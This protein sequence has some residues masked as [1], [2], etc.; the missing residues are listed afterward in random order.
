MA[1]FTVPD[2]LRDP[3]FRKLPRDQQLLGLR[4]VDAEFGGLPEEAQLAALDDPEFQPSSNLKHVEPPKSSVPGM[5]RLGDLPRAGA[6]PARPEYN[7]SGDKTDALTKAGLYVDETVGAVFRPLADMQA[8]VGAAMETKG[9]LP[10]VGKA[11]RE[12]GEER[13][14]YW[15]PRSEDALKALADNP[16]VLGNVDWWLNRGV[17]TA[18]QMVAF[19]AAGEAV[20]P[21]AGAV[22]GAAGTSAKVGA[23]AELGAGLLAMSGLEVLV[24][25]GGAAKQVYE[26]TGNRELA[27]KVFDRTA[28]YEAVPTV[29]GNL[30]GLKNP[31][32]KSALSKV[33]LSMLSEGA[34]EGAQGVSQRYAYNVTMEEAGRPER[35]SLWRNVPEEALVGGL[36]GGGIG[37]VMEAAGDRAAARPQATEVQ[38]GAAPALPEPTVERAPFQPS[39]EQAQELANYVATTETGYVSVLKT[40]KL[41]GSSLDDARGA[42]D[43]MVDLG[44]LKRTG[45]GQYKVAAQP[46]AA[47]AVPASPEVS[48][49]PAPV[50]NEKEEV[51]LAET[52][53]EEIPAETVET[54][55]PMDE[56]AQ[57]SAE[58]V[59]PEAQ[60]K[61]PADETAKTVADTVQREAETVDP[62]PETVPLVDKTKTRSTIKA[63]LQTIRDRRKN[64]LARKVEPTTPTT[65]VFPSP[66]STQRESGELAAPLYSKGTLEQRGKAQRLQGLL[67]E[68][69]EFRKRT[70]SAEAENDFDK[71][72]NLTAKRLTPDFSSGIRRLT[73]NRLTLEAHK[74][75]HRADWDS[76][77]LQEDL[78]DHR[79]RIQGA[80]TETVLRELLNLPVGPAVL[81]E[82]IRGRRDDATMEL[83]RSET[84]E[85]GSLLLPS[86]GKTLKD[87][88]VA[89]RE[90]R[91]A[92][93]A[94]PV[95]PAAAQ[96]EQPKPQSEEPVES[97]IESFATKHYVIGKNEAIVTKRGDG[98]H[99]AVVSASKTWGGTIGVPGLSSGPFQSAK[100]AQ[101]ASLS[102]LL[103]RHIIETFGR[104]DRGDS[105]KASVAIASQVLKRQ[106]ELLGDKAAPDVM[107]QYR[108]LLAFARDIGG[109]S[110]WR[111][112]SDAKLDAVVDQ[113][114]ADII[115]GNAADLF[116]R[117]P[118]LQVAAEAFG[119]TTPAK[120]TKLLIS[121]P[122]KADKTKVKAGGKSGAQKPTGTSELAAT[123]AAGNKDPEA[124]EGAPAGDVPAVGEP[125]SATQDGSAGSRPVRGTDDRSLPQ[126]DGLQQ[127]EGD[128]PDGAGLAPG[129]DGSTDVDAKP[130]P[131]TTPVDLSKDYR[132]TPEDRLGQGGE[133]TKADDNIAALE[134][135]KTLREEGREATAE[136]KRKLVRYVG[137]GGLAQ[138]IFGYDYRASYDERT[139]WAERR[140]KVADLLSP[141]EYQA[142]QRSTLNAHYTSETVVSAMWRAV[143]RLGLKDGLRVLEP[144]SGTGN[145]FGLMPESML[146]GSRRMA[147]EIDP[148]TAE[149]FKHLYPGSPI[150]N[151]PY[152][153]AVIPSSYFDL[154]I[155][156]VPFADVRVV[157]PAFRRNRVVTQSV[158]DYFFA[159]AMEHVRPGGLVAFIT[160]R[161]TMDKQD[162]RVREYLADR[163]D[164]IGAWRLPNTAFRENARTEVDTDVLFLRKRAEGE[165]R[166]GADWLQLA[167]LKGLE[168]PTWVNEYFVAHP[169]MVL[170]TMELTR[171][172][173][174]ANE[175]TV[176]G[177]L[178]PELLEKAINALPENIIQPPKNPA[179]APTNQFIPAAEFGDA[180]D[181][182]IG[183]I[184]EKDGKFF[185]KEKTGFAELKI[186]KTQENRMRG[187]LAVRTAVREV[188]REQLAS[189]DDVALQ[190]AQRAL[191]KTYDEFVAKFGPISS[192][193]N[194]KWI[195]ED[196]DN[197][198]LL[199][200]ESKYDRKAGTV[201]KTAIFTKRTIAR[202]RAAESAATAKEGM[203]ITLAER[204]RLDIG[205]IAELVGRTQ[206]QVIDD[207]VA[208]DLIFNN[209]D[210]GS[211]QVAEEYLSGDVRGKLRL[212]ER[213]AKVD[214]KFERNVVALRAVQPVDLEPKDISAR[215]GA[216]WIPAEVYAEFLETVLD[217]PSGLVKIT[218]IATLGEWSVDAG[219]F[220]KTVLATKK[221]GTSR[222]AADELMERLLNAKPII[223]IDRDPDGRSWKN[224]SE[225]VLAQERADALNAEFERWLW[226]S[227]HA[228][229]LAKLYN[230]KFNNW[231]LRKYNG[232]HLTFPGMAKGFLRANDLDPHQE[233]R[234][235]RAELGQYPTGARGGR[236]QNLRDDR[237]RRGAEAH[238]PRA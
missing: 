71:D 86:E 220:G 70:E 204:G 50:E 178:T 110:R 67:T 82:W 4:E 231:V 223:V 224:E 140:R 152:Q 144:A 191:G 91:R 169:E 199:A 41:L 83:Q 138:K 181:L 218:E 11:I 48:Q 151:L 198:L 77:I 156:N 66:D 145:F 113:A 148:V 15:A 74:R 146:D 161:Y 214:S 166:A 188:F 195:S 158:H 210:G 174:R 6:M 98:Y 197:P 175:L 45:N 163:A 124:L 24:D 192:K 32:V 13:A 114:K 31:A 141:E 129:G 207:L 43:A 103:G 10:G 128:R 102:H 119:A 26:Q 227:R 147:V 167:E 105:T 159:K 229:R 53:V 209:P 22:A 123:N 58:T 225:T 234:M 60:T 38:R 94:E 96:I 56:T 21:A 107:Q 95:K 90:R 139:A 62:E 137:W 25:A 165:E 155:S 87:R 150:Q 118:M 51:P 235:A 89:A 33:A 153:E 208:E 149:I 211:W 189:D 72:V 117:M 64:R 42:L 79:E 76:E 16:E 200:L 194:Q 157:D 49:E 61:A 44:I 136:E 237:R 221:W 217:L 115:N 75:Q 37:G 30:I 193:E 202:P 46:A 112:T 81:E 106:R 236:G 78:Q 219:N 125:G 121:E 59:E 226:S 23:A 34:Q 9:I 126:G 8:N 57:A 104:G 168:S 216:S 164:L 132:I 233:R 122:G 215:I 109:L 230:E 201:E 180:R 39:E 111:D 142:A 5:E 85:G 19:I 36:F 120:L 7:I 184:T 17:E 101:L 65:E 116:K 190:K 3:E 68:V 172:M 80:K 27:A 179:A 222:I 185:T 20:G 54:V 135:L 97:E 2:L 35:E 232:A 47:E 14:A 213:I 18:S 131:R 55:P 1:T 100:E 206:E 212:A 52:A 183:N 170:G 92:R 130:R 177:P 187:L 69:S 93:Q 134:V 154:V 196:P 173:H 108:E 162:S 99:V 88:I 143:Q 28:T 171:G 182:R 133:A 127:S 176:K 238:R 186:P 29:A 12:Q 228:D 73:L 84:R 40:K 160:S 203:L 63:R 205:R